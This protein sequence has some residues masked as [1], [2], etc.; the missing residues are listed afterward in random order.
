MS[1]PTRYIHTGFYSTKAEML[2][3][4]LHN[5][6]KFYLKRQ[7]ATQRAMNLR[8]LDV[9]RAIDGEVCF[10]CN[11]VY[12]RRAWLRYVPAFNGYTDQ[13][14]LLEIG[15]MLKTVALNLLVYGNRGNKLRPVKARAL[16]GDKA[17]SRNNTAKFTTAD[18]VELAFTVADVYYVYENFIGRPNLSRKYKADIIEGLRSKPLDP[19]MV[20]AKKAALEDIARRKEE[21]SKK[22]Y[23]LEREYEDK[24]SQI[25]ATLQNEKNE[26][27][28]AAQAEVNAEIDK[29]EKSI[30]AMSTL[31]FG[32]AT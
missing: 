4:S 18:D 7:A 6:M 2:L 22:K 19:I 30:A 3:D 17:W 8:Q 16:D 12:S 21:F 23:E 13:K 20:E 28:T 9:I 27:I 14:A 26:K 24:Y 1:E 11:E 10:R 5:N 31:A 15:A 29:I 32:T 25:R